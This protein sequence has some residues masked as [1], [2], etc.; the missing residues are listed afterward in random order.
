MNHNIK[1]STS[2]FILCLTLY[3][4]PLTDLVNHAT[5]YCKNFVLSL[6]DTVTPD[7]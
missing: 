7:A 6:V 1:T 2:S 4:F 5:I 3:S